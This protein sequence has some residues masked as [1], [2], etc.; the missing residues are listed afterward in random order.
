MVGTIAS[1]AR[2]VTCLGACRGSDWHHRPIGRT[3]QARPPG[4]S[5]PQVSA[6]LL[7]LSAGTTQAGELDNALA[8]LIHIGHTPLGRRWPP[9]SGSTGRPSAGIRS[10]GRPQDRRGR[11]FR[12]LHLELGDSRGCP[13]AHGGRSGGSGLASTGAIGL[14]LALGVPAALV[15]LTMASCVGTSR[16][17][18]IVVR[19]DPARPKRPLRNRKP[20]PVKPSYAFRGHHWLEHHTKVAGGRRARRRGNRKA[21]TR[22]C[23]CA[24]AP[25]PPRHGKR[26]KARIP[27][28]DR[29]AGAPG[30]ISPARK[31]NPSGSVNR[32]TPL[33]DQ[34]TLE[35]RRCVDGPAARCGDQVHGET[36]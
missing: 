34:P 17:E 5:L 2:S 15:G 33:P 16:A 18:L 9:E 7:A 20:Q 12:R 14:A 30:R 31:P 6:V 21:R 32:Q 3:A 4:A 11:E 29:P 24:A 1:P 8:A 10:A 22:S 35:L 26:S 19:V 23:R 27:D 13:A 36:R 28:A 25:C